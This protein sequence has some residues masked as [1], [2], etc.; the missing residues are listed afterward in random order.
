MLPR[1]T[2]SDLLH[3]WLIASGS[4]LRIEQTPVWQPPGSKPGPIGNAVWRIM[5]GLTD[6]VLAWVHNDPKPFVYVVGNGTFWPEDPEFFAKLEIA[7]GVNN[8][9]ASRVSDKPDR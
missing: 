9:G 1:P 8:G 5:P 7:L 4:G 3:E 2:L 6:I